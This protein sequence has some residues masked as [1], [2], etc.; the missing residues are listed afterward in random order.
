MP[1]GKFDYNTEL[2]SDASERPL[3]QV[4]VAMARASEVGDDGLDEGRG[5]W[6]VG[7]HWGRCGEDEDGLDSRGLRGMV[8]RVEE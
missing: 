1:V 4:W 8:N 3:P 2:A 7:Q 5:Q 6:R